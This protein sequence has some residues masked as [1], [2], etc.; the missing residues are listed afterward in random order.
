M[1]KQPPHKDGS[2]A[3]SRFALLGIYNVQKELIMEKKNACGFGYLIRRAPLILLF[4]ISISGCPNREKSTLLTNPEEHP[5]E[6]AGVLMVLAQGYVDFNT[7][8]N[9]SATAE[10]V[11]SII[12]DYQNYA[13]YFPDL[14]DSI[15]IISDI[16]SGQG[17][18]WKSTG[19]FKGRTF[20]TIWE[21]T[22]YIANEKVVMRDTQG[23]GVVTLSVESIG[24][25]ESR[26]AYSAH[27]YMFLPFKYEFFRIF[28]KEADAVKSYSESL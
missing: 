8:R 5:L 12:T 17:V 20:T 22:E 19:S 14:H 9:I 28:E 1:Q 13:A 10:N 26:Y 16:K 3:S 21:V 25:N 15:E 24:L 18:V 6:A 27:I 7:E 11:F 4:F 23:E 2:S